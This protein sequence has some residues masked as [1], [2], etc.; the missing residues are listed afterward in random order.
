[1][2]SIEQAIDVGAPLYNQGNFE[3]CY[4]IYEGAALG[5][6]QRVQQCQGP[7]Q[8]LLQGVDAAKKQA[9]WSDKAWAMRDAFDGLLALSSRSAAAAHGVVPVERHI[10]LVPLA[11]V[12]A[13]PTEDITSIA[14]SIDA[15]IRS[16]A[17]LYN[18][19]NVEACY[20]IYEGAV[21][22]IERKSNRCQ[23]ARQVLQQGI[24]NAD[25]VD[26][27]SAKAWA[28]RD[29][30]DGLLNAIVTHQGEAKR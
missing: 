9:S 8:A 23:A 13:C 15:A 1:V 2:S 20:R 7:K 27:W 16:G 18:S 12:E 30:F 21:S 14:T 11:V 22:E 6:Q 17:P 25:R 10:P 28:L 4:R 29:S 24:S 19:G 5:I 26:D 3:A